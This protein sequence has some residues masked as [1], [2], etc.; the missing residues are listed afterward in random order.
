MSFIFIVNIISPTVFANNLNTYNSTEITIVED[1]RDS[2]VI[3]S[4][5]TEETNKYEIYKNK[6]SNSIYTIKS[7]D[8]NIFVY[9]YDKL[10]HEFNNKNDNI[11]SFNKLY[12][13][14]TTWNWQYRYYTKK[15]IVGEKALIISLLASTLGL[16]AG[17]V[18]S[19]G[20]HIYTKGIEDVY[21]TEKY[22]YIIDS[23]NESMKKERYIYAYENSDRTR[24]IDV[25]HTIDKVAWD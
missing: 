15:D 10:I 7:F 2:Y 21:F 12:R 4:K 11:S 17:L 18:T 22:R 23:E 6:E 19:L 16:A 25:V 20:I 5:M 8:E 9:K 13:S 3:V 24:L 1:N 14:V